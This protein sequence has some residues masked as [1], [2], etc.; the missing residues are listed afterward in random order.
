MG[1]GGLIT[2]LVS[3]KSSAEELAQVYIVAFKKNGSEDNDIGTWALQYWPESVTISQDV[4]YATKDILGGSHPLRQFLNLGDRV[5]GFTAEFSRDLQGEV[6]DSTMVEAPGKV[7]RSRFNV[8]IAAAHTWIESLKLP[9]YGPAT[10]LGEFEP[11]PLLW[12]VFPK[13]RFGMARGF[14]DAFQSL[15]VSTTIR[16]DSWF[17]DGTIRHS[18][19]DMAFAEVVQTADGISFFGRDHP[20]FEIG[21]AG[22]GFW[23]YPVAK[24]TV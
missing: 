11:P 8:D 5:L 7:S 4:N 2:S 16:V 12:V 23:K 3:K 6:I 20:V 18:Q 1:V 19:V 17:P 14:S 10:S 24:R 21:K 9:K 13:S 15:L 22:G